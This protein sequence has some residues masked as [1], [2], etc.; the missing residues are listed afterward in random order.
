MAP[1]MSC[2]LIELLSIASIHDDYDS[3]EEIVTGSKHIE[4]KYLFTRRTLK[5][6]SVDDELP[7][8]LVAAQGMGFALQD[9]VEA[10]RIVPFIDDHG[11]FG[12]RSLLVNG[13][14]LGDVLLI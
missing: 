12:H 7:A 8:R 5:V 11:V 1:W 3:N 13:L 9:D 2:S 10:T 14:E 6:K 4:G